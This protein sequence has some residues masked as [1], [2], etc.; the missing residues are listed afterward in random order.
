MNLTAH[1]QE[2]LNAAV[3]RGD[4]R[5][6]QLTAY[7]DGKL[8]VDIC[9]GYL[10]ADH[11][12]PVT[13][14]TLFPVFSVTKGMCATI[15]HMLVE[16]GIISY[17]TPIAQVW[18][19]FA[20]EGKSGITV[21]HALNHT[22]GLQNMPSNIGYAEMCSW[23]AICARI[24]A[25]A[26]VS[27]P[28]AQMVYHA[29]TFGFILGEVARR[30]TGQPFADL[31]QKQIADPLH[32]TSMYCGIPEDID[33]RI[34]IL[35]EIFDPGAT[36]SS[37]DD[38]AARPVP[39]WLMPLHTMMNRPDARRACIPASNGIMNARSIA[40]HYAALLP[41][42]VDG[43]KLLPPARVRLVTQRQYPSGPQENPPR[44]ALGYFVGGENSEFGSRA[45]AFGHGGY[46]GST[47]FTD[48]EYKLAVGFTKNLYSKRAAHGAILNA[49][50]AAL[51]IPS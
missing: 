18:P 11:K 10:D 40:R 7:L 37:V 21:R 3:S 32:I 47:G 44:I 22:A 48:P 5:G 50:R 42:G 39:A 17:E 4:E 34:A 28:G 9:A 15:I 23:D 12:H 20:A 27:P 38:G 46:G 41:G 1:M 24:A 6:L 36:P 35:E 19:E 14:D 29:I 30:V 43:V 25:M 2:I 13:P 45:N 49:L 31:L 8:V 26:P 16:R 33:S 51:K